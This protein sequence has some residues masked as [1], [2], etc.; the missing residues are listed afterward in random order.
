MRVR[1]RWTAGLLAVAVTL[2][3]TACGS[4]SD[5]GD[6]SS[7]D[8]LPVATAATSPTDTA[9]PAGTV[10]AQD[11]AT[12]IAVA[13][14]TTAVL[15]ADGRTVTLHHGAGQDAPAPNRVAL[16]IDGVVDLIAL[17]DH[18]LAVGPRGL[19]RVDGDGRTSV[20]DA[21]IDSPLSLAVDGDKVLVGTAKGKVLVLSAAGERID[22]FGGFA[23]VDDILVAPTS[24]TDVEGQ[25]SVFDR[26]QSAILPIDVESGD[27]KAS[28]RAGN[29]ATNAVVD[30]F[31][32]IM[33]TGTRDDEFYA[34]FGDPIVMRLRHPAPASPFALAY[35]EKHDLL[36]VSSTAENEAVAY[37]LSR[38]DAR[39]RGRVPTV[40]Q[41]TAMAV[42]PT[43][44][45][46]L[47]ASGRGD[48]LQVVAPT[49]I[50]S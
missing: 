25:V 3:L 41:V 45:D 46:L 9:K 33:V 12:A 22:E 47:L 7:L 20:A 27:R 10:V 37:D 35:D 42:D 13:G 15:G 26:A 1:T 31:G 50:A 28:L 5:D 4:D 21:P 49:V 38:G 48:G 30:R 6:S 43:S 24:A 39:E 8:T 23:R 44:G 32:R 29:G 19:V 34:F 36:W 40:G 17:D 2:T 11:A 16:P 18:F 14:S